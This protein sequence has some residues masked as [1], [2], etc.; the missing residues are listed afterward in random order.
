MSDDDGD[1]CGGVADSLSDEDDDE[2]EDGS[3]CGCV[4]E[5]VTV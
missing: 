1:D 5:R 2:Q 3:D 4:V